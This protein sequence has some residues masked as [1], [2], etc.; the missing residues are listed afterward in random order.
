MIFFLKNENLKRIYLLQLSDMPIFM[1]KQLREPLEWLLSKTGIEK[2]QVQVHPQLQKLTGCLWDSLSLSLSQITLPHRSA[3]AGLNT[4]D[5]SLEGTLSSW[6]KGRRYI[7]QRNKIN[8][9]RLKYFPLWS[10]E[11]AKSK[12]LYRNIFRL[13]MPLDCS[14]QFLRFPL[15]YQNRTNKTHRSSAQLCGSTT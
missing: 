14:H 11:T 15:G 1:D 9:Y 13:F 7:Y 8:N 4:R 5:L 3:L 6:R 10:E 2:N 12:L